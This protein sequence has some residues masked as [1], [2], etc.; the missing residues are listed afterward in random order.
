MLTWNRGIVWQTAAVSWNQLQYG[1]VK[2]ESG[3]LC[4]AASDAVYSLPTEFAADDNPMKIDKHC[5]ETTLHTTVSTGN[6]WRKMT[7]QM[8]GTTT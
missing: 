6:T 3:R 2:V 1:F 5:Y 7:R 8:G 4:I